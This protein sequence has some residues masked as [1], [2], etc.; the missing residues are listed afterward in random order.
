MKYDL[1]LVFTTFR[2]C[3]VYL[4][5]VK[6]L[7][8]RYNVGVYECSIVN[9]DLVKVDKQNKLFLE[10]IYSYGATPVNEDKVDC[11][12]ALLPQWHYRK[13][14]IELIFDKLNCGHK[15]WMVSLAMGNCSYENLYGHEVDKIL[16]VD[17][18]FYNFRLSKRPFEKELAIAEDKIVE[19]GTPYNDYPVFNDLEIDYI[20]ANPTPF[21]FPEL[22]DKLK[23]LNNLIA[24][25]DKISGDAVIAYKPHNATGLDSLVNYKVLKT[26]RLYV[27]FF[28]KKPLRV[29]FK[30]IGVMFKHKRIKKIS[31]ELEIIEK[32]ER[33]MQRIVSLSSLT[34]YHSFNLEMFLPIV[35]KGLITGRSNS[36]W[37]ALYARLPVYNCVSDSTVE[38]SKNK[39]HSYNMRYFDVNCCAGHLIFDSDKFNLIKDETR[40]ADIVKYVEA[41]L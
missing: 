18:A 12:V 26:L 7:Y 9:A 3:G 27:P 10:L 1:I 35:R 19:V 23:Y 8:G 16:V 11:T 20:L 36:I 14:D 2:K 4:P 40:L 22:A 39:M 21:S 28:L 41:H 5:L 15:F 32:Y 38:V 33:L 17:R 30:Y 24:L 31:V 34:K 29:I 37:H 6:Q 13:N 25:I